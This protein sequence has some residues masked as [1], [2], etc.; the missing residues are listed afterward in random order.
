[1]SFLAV[2][3]KRYLIKCRLI[4]QGEL[5]PPPPFGTKSHSGHL[6]FQQTSMPS[7]GRH[8]GEQ[9]SLPVL[10]CLWPVFRFSLLLCPVLLTNNAFLC[11]FFLPPLPLLILLPLHLP[12]ACHLPT[13]VL[14]SQN[15]GASSNSLSLAPSCRRPQDL[16]GGAGLPFLRQGVGVAVHRWVR[17]PGQEG[18][19]V[20]PETWF[21]HLSPLFS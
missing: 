20:G 2:R 15:T 7:V 1:M 13:S 17:F 14:T 5:S 6:S 3:G 10:K 19:P 21:E 9:G 18:G 8:K 12:I 4:L 11:F 16:Q